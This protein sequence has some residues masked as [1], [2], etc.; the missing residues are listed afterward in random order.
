MELREGRRKTVLFLSTLE[1]GNGIGVCKCVFLV[2]RVG[3][4]PTAR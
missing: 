4:E 3:V 2:G 1:A